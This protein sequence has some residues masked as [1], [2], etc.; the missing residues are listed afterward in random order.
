MEG[1]LVSVESGH[2]AGI[3][4]ID[5]LETTDLITKRKERTF[6]MTDNVHNL[7]PT[8]GFESFPKI[9]A[10]NMT[11]LHVYDAPNSPLLKNVSNNFCREL[12]ADQNLSE[13]GSSKDNDKACRDDSENRAWQVISSARSAMRYFRWE[14]RSGFL[15]VTVNEAVFKDHYKILSFALGSLVDGI[16]SITFNKMKGFK[17]HLLNTWYPT[18]KLREVENEIF[19]VPRNGSLASI[20]THDEEHCDRKH[21]VRFMLPSEWAKLHIETYPLYEEVYLRQKCFSNENLTF[22]FATVCS[23]REQC[24]GTCA[25]TCLS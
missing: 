12:R 9:F 18:S 23:R 10:N 20:Q 8:S 14:H 1:R 5:G 16:N 6:F 3:L 4:E 13:S 22:Y 17:K 11:Q 2:K 19:K 15:W 7:N 21:Y 24:P 25:T